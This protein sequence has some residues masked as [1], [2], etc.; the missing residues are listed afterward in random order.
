[1]ANIEIDGRQVTAEPG[2]MIIEAADHFG[3]W[4]PRFCYHKKLSIAANCRMCL[5]EV[6]KSGKP[7]PA[8]ATPITDG[9]KIKTRSP[10]ALMA[11]KAV[12]EFLLINHPLDCPICDQGGECELQDIAMGYG[13]DHSRFEE[14]KRV[15]KDKN[16]GPLIATNMTRCIQCTRCVRFGTEIAGYRELGAY[17]RGEH[18]EIGTFI[19]RN[20]D[21]EVSGN[22]IDLCPVGALLSKPFLFQAR[23][24]ELQQ[25]PSIAA[26]DCIGSNIYIHTRRNEVLRV[27]PRENEAINEIWISDRDRF[28]YEALYCDRLEVP[29]IKVNGQWRKSNWS[30]ALSFTAEKLK[31][32][33]ENEGGAA[34]AALASPNLTTEEFYLLQK[35]T[36]GLG[37]TQI[38]HRLRQRDFRDQ[39]MFPQY[40]GLNQTLAE[41]EQQSMLLLIGSD[42]RNEQPVLNLKF[43]KMALAGKKIAA[44]NPIDFSFCFDLSEKVIVPE[45][46]L[47]LGLAE[48]LRA[49]NE[50]VS[51]EKASQIPKNLRSSLANIMPS[52]ASNH[53]AKLLKTEAQT[54]LLLG[55]YA[56]THPQASLIYKLASVICRLSGAK[57]GFL[58]EGAN[59]AGGYLAGCLPHRLPGGQRVEQKGKVVGS[60]SPME[61]L[62]KKDHTLKAMILAGFEP[63]LDCANG[64][65]VMESLKN[66]PFVVAL[67][68][69]E[70]D[71]LKEIATVLLPI[72]PFTETSGTFINAEGRW[73]SFNEVAPP[74]CE[75]R[76]AWKVLRVLGNACDLTGFEFENSA[77]VITELLSHQTSYQEQNQNI[78]S[79]LIENSTENLTFDEGD[80]SSLFENHH[81]NAPIRLGSVPLYAC[82]GLVRR[83]AAL[84]KTDQAK[85]V[86][87][88]NPN[89]AKNLNLNIG[90]SAR[91]IIDGQ[92]LTLP[93]V[94]DPRIPEQS[95]HI[96]LVSQTLKLGDAYLPVDIKHEILI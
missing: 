93:L 36:R 12:M 76:P 4:I 9:M 69:F 88:M 28:S 82:D 90:D 61:A 25:K 95:I 10:K 80:L 20:V 83:A 38:D 41:L 24:F 18:L 31:E 72:S 86:A 60:A 52:D 14:G 68:S 71:T 32:T 85:I 3:I 40:L 7:L 81:K 23:G 8:C 56:L 1:M 44:I 94:L 50:Q 42:T 39:E 63:D 45:G 19:E 11:Q 84:Q 65:K 55:A 16:I 66:M 54:T 13:Q 49:L 26:H 43:R 53:I 37:S 58:S 17:G 77:E 6:E 5:V 29:K 79:L 22:V 87:T 46:N 73:Q 91:F 30:E 89:L 70:S 35:L 47:C 92:S 62:L 15:V 78:H 57:L 34:L 74:F 48:I 59:S 96:P 21:S 75:S 51:E 33:V 67:T 2:S 27:V 64:L